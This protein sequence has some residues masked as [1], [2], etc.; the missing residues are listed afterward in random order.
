MRDKLVLT[1]FQSVK[2]WV[3]GVMLFVFQTVAP[4][5][6]KQMVDQNIGKFGDMLTDVQKKINE[7]NKTIT[8]TEE[9]KCFTIDWLN[10]KD[11]AKTP[12][13]DSLIKLQDLFM[14]PSFYCNSDVRAFVDQMKFIPPARI[15]LELLGLPTTDRAY[16]DVCWNLPPDVI[17]GGLDIAILH[18]LKPVIRPRK[19]FTPATAVPEDEA[20]KFTGTLEEYNKDKAAKYKKAYGDCPGFD[21]GQLQVAAA[22][23]QAKLS[24]VFSLGATGATGAPGETGAALTSFAGNIRKGSTEAVGIAAEGASAA[25]K[26]AK[27]SAQGIIGQIKDMK[28]PQLGIGAKQPT[29][30]MM[31]PQGGIA[32]VHQP[33]VTPRSTPLGPLGTIVHPQGLTLPQQVASQ[34]A[35]SVTQ[36]LLGPGRGPIIIPR[37]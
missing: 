15:I 12:D 1:G 4:L 21:M 27:E 36:G 11:P 28:T 33:G 31:P 35:S 20:E 7:V 16:S 8:S 2:S 6:I 13:Y 25:G 30:A 26:K 9:F 19:P 14:Q 24:S 37:G 29:M 3:L 22:K 32:V 17:Q 23:A 18:S 34:A 5:A 10:L